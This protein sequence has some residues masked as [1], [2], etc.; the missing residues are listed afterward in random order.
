MIRSQH[1]PNKIRF[2][3][4]L[5]AILL[6]QACSSSDVFNEYKPLTGSVWH[7]DSVVTF[8]PELTDTLSPCKLVVDLRHTGRFAF[9]NVWAVVEAYAPD[10][11]LWLKDTLRIQLADRHGD[12]LG[13]GSGQLLDREILYRSG[14]V[15]DRPGRYR[16]VV[17]HCMYDT[18]MPEITHIGLRIS[19]QNGEK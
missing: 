14:L 6:L 1:H 7:R 4:G 12:W 13:A 16:F 15:F 8:L 3:L 9:S 17:Q 10:S 18:L 19:Y 2:S 5:L 11:S